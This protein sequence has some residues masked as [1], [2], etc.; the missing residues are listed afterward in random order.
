MTESKKTI[1]FAKKIKD[2]ATS[3]IATIYLQKR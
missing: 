1:I 3:D 2:N